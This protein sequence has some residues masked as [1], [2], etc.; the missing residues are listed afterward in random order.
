MGRVLPDERDHVENKVP[1]KGWIKS[2]NKK[3]KGSS[4]KMKRSLDERAHVEK[5]GIKEGID[6]K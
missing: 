2:R 6:K 1:K 3:G 4:K 5:Q